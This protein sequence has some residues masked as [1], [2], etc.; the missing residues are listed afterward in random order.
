MKGEDIKK[1][2]PQRAPILMVD[3]LLDVN[4]EEA[5]TSLTIRSD[6]FFIDEDE[7]LEES[8]LIEHIAQ[9][10]SAFAGYRTRLDGAVKP[11]IGYIG[12][13]KNFRCYHRPQA[14]DKLHTT[15]R[16]GPEVGGVMLLSGETCI[17]AKTV[18]DTQMK[19]FIQPGC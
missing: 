6:N 3:E 13:V 2:L 7:R 9:S 19:I 8:G 11:P 17:G 4:G 14:G 16:L 12:E 15:I 10:A 5:Q 1:L 18:A